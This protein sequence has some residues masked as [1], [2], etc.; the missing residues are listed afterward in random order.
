MPDR[1]APPRWLKPMNK[2]L[3]LM[4]RVGVPISRHEAPVVL[5]V[6]GR[7]TGKP[8]S[9]PITPMLVD[10][11]RFV[12]NAYP[13]ADWVGNVRAAE[14]ATLTQGRRTEQVRFVELSA[15]DARP[16]LREFPAQV[17]TGVDLMKRAGVLQTGTP[18]ELERMA[19]RLAVFRIDPVT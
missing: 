12:V 6:A 8:R 13:G 4:L 14:R 5:T 10:G 19:G 15:D 2:L 17:A 3:I 7:K 1:V 9:T 18:E 16:V 11:K